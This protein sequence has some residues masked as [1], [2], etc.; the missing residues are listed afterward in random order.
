[1]EQK[2][3][4]FKDKQIELENLLADLNQLSV[5]TYKYNYKYGEYHTITVWQSYNYRQLYTSKRIEDLIYLVKMLIKYR[6]AEYE[7]E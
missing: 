3:T 7:A 1:M 5:K 2:P 6:V 4:A